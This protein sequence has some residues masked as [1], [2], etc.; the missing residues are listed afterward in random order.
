MSSRT[1]PN[2]ERNTH[3]IHTQIIILLNIDASQ[4]SRHT[5]MHVVRRTFS[6]QTLK[7]QCQS[8]SMSIDSIT[9]RFISFFPVVVGCMYLSL[10]LF[11]SLRFQCTVTGKNEFGISQHPVD[12]K[13]N[14]VVKMQRS[15]WMYAHIFRSFS[16][17][18]LLVSV[19][20]V[21]DCIVSHESTQHCTENAIEL[22]PES[23][24][25]LC[26]YQNAH[27]DQMHRKCNVCRWF[28][29]SIHVIVV[30]IAIVAVVISVHWALSPSVD[31]TK[32]NVSRHNILLLHDSVV[33]FS[34]SCTSDNLPVER[35]P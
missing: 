30:V 33:S 31:R 35:T 18:L 2:Q 34:C 10:V 4:A 20:S 17:C 32:I 19:C 7:L 16:P 22:F 29:W 13:W 26:T 8:M 6:R 27:T 1:K 12:G 24:R 14:S 23:R 11:M 25:E 28:L 21:Y 9:F 5:R 15:T 3:E